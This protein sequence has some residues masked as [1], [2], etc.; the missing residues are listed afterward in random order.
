MLPQR[1][2]RKLKIMKGDG[3]DDPAFARL[4]GG[5]GQ[6]KQLLRLREGLFSGDAG[7]VTKKR[8]ARA[9]APGEVFVHSLDIRPGERVTWDFAVLRGWADSQLGES[10]V[11]FRVDAFWNPVEAST[12][13][14]QVFESLQAGSGREC[15]RSEER[16]GS[17]RGR[18]QGGHTASRSGVVWLRW[19][20]AH[21][22]L[23]SKVVRFDVRVF[24]AAEE[25][26][27]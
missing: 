23:R 25:K 15:L 27:A 11:R 26:I 16:I 4:V 21:S 9:V 8:G 6:L 13:H 24:G 17:S 2:S 1:F 10:D 5:E 19:S 18:V 14:R 20:N 3:V 22:R 12:H 7:K